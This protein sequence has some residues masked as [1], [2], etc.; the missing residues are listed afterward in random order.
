[1]LAK[2]L[3]ESGLGYETHKARVE[4]FTE[5][6][7]HSYAVNDPA[8]SEFMELFQLDISDGTWPS[9]LM[10]TSYGYMQSNEE[11]AFGVVAWTR[12]V[13][14][15]NDVKIQGVWLTPVPS[16][17]ESANMCAFMANELLCDLDDMEEEVIFP[18]KCDGGLFDIELPEDA[19]T[20]ELW[21]ADVDGNSCLHPSIKSLRST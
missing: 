2:D 20:N 18:F 17:L 19:V 9:P 1:V 15:T 5:Y 6:C 10:V 8:L 11:I 12:F 4:R 21:V 3:K 13:G 14:G 16:K 7:K